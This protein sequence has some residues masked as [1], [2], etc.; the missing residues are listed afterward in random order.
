[1]RTCINYFL[2]RPARFFAFFSFGLSAEYVA[3]GSFSYVRIGDNMDIF[4]PRLVSQWQGFW[5]EGFSNWSALFAGGIDRLANDM[6][7][8]NAGG[9]IFALF[10]AWLAMGLLL[11]GTL[12]LG[13]WYT[14][15]I[16]REDL[17]RSHGASIL[18]GMFFSL[19]LI[20]TDIIPYLLGLSIVPVV[21]YY[22]PRV[23][24]LSDMKRRYG[25]A[26]LLGLLFAFFS[27][28]PFTLPF[29]LSAIAVWFIVVRKNYT[30]R[31][32]LVFVL[33]AIA[34]I[35]PHIPV[36][37]HLVVNAP[38][39]NRG[40]DFY[41][42]GLSYARATFLTF[43]TSY[44]FLG[45]L[46]LAGLLWLRIRERAFLWAV[47]L[48]GLF[49]TIGVWYQPFATRFGEH[50]RLVKDFGF[51]RFYLLIPFF[52]TI[53]SAYAIDALGERKAGSYTLRKIGIAVCIIFVGV[54]MIDLKIAHARVWLREGSFYAATHSPVMEK[55]RERNLQEPFRVATIADER[56]GLRPSLANMNGF[57]TI[58]GDI[59]IASKRY[60]EFFKTMTKNP[61][62]EPKHSF[63]LLWQAGAEERTQAASDASAL[64]DPALLSLANVRFLLSP[65]PVALTGFDL[66]NAP[67]EVAADVPSFKEAWKIN[68]RGRDLYLYENSDVFPRAF[69]VDDAEK[70]P[71]VKKVQRAEIISYG[72]D[73]I[74]MAI[75]SSTPGVLVLT[76]NYNPAW[77]VLVDGE[78]KKIMPV[79][80]TFMG[81]AIEQGN[82]SVVWT[83]EKNN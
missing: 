14:Y 26:I 58:D 1:M 59:N 57:E 48:V 65:F 50:F 9:V 2:Q 75:A 38:L 11:L 27:S 78:E 51:D 10:P 45:A 74:E 60:V 54:A 34:A 24:T 61:A 4:I 6:T 83:Y 20:Q 22:L 47:F 30:R 8:F 12:F 68:T 13:G 21:L 32:L 79:Y 25:G 31:A 33:F 18:A 49:F 56:T 28:V 53:G 73:R 80:T 3:L 29:T 44:W 5:T 39:S 46:T 43:V 71:D 23:A 76:N 15:R 63:Y 66:I 7:Y 72:N 16:V 52:L 64:L 82:Y 62:V 36:V 69:L 55:I 77:H 37:G 42:A 67:A 40:G 70:M 35:L 41:H 17:K 81:V 19:A